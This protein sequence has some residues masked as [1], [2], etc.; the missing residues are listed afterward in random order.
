MGSAQDNDFIS[1]SND[2][3]LKFST[4]FLEPNGSEKK[5]AKTNQ[6]LKA[7]ERWRC[8]ASS[9]LCQTCQASNLGTQATRQ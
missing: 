7:F 9:L 2:F 6:S 5:C 1:I 4:Q 3:N 8:L